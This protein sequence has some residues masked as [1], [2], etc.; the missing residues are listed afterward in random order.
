[1]WIL[2]ILAS[3]VVTANCH[4]YLKYPVARTAIQKFDSEFGTQPPYY[5][6]YTGVWCADARQDLDY[7]QCGRCGERVGNN[8]FSQGGMYDKGVIVANWTSGST[9]DILVEIGVPHNG[10]FQ[11]ELCSEETETDNCFHKLNII[12][13]S[14]PIRTDQTMC[15][16]KQHRH[17]IRASVQLPEGVSCNRCTVRWTYRTHYNEPDNPDYRGCDVQQLSRQVFRN[18]ADVAIY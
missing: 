6:D 7:S 5:F 11:L 13:G 1:M 16:T 2:L 10:Q 17:E 3:V 12:D 18:C 14:E 4:G 8:E 9:V 15:V